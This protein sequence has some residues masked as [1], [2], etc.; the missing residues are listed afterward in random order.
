MRNSW[1]ICRALP[2]LTVGQLAARVGIAGA[3]RVV[4]GA[5]LVVEALIHAGGVGRR[6]VGCLLI[7]IEHVLHLAERLTDFAVLPGIDRRLIQVGL[8]PPDAHVLLLLAFD[9]LEQAR[10]PRILRAK[11]QRVLQRLPG[12]AVG[13]VVD[14]L[15]RQ[16]DP[17]FD[18]ALAAAIL[19]LAL[20]PERGDVGRIEL[21]HFLQLLQRQ[22]ILFLLVPG[23][24]AL[25]QLADGLLTRDLVD[26]GAQ[27][28][29]LRIDVALGLE[30]GDD[31]AGKLEV[32]LLERL[33]RRLDARLRP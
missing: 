29:D 4:L 30:L 6:G 28:R 11:D 18:L 12:V 22:R 32:A 14:V 21:Q 2:R 13:V 1:Q 15:P 7:Q 10:R 25:E 31:L 33:R 9:L 20:E 17:L 24:C 19:D 23:P 27:Q 5:K 26:L 8:L 16:L 3:D